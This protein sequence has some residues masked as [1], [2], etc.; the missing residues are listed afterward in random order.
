MF[1]LKSASYIFFSVLILSN[2]GCA[3]S[4]AKPNVGSA[5]TGS[6]AETSA[7]SSGEGQIDTTRE[8]NLSS[9]S[10]PDQSKGGKSPAWIN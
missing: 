7:Q 9:A 1:D 3:P 5:G 10:S 2:T 6:S 4:T 8:S